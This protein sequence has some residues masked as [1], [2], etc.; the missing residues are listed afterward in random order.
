M[1]KVAVADVRRIVDDEEMSIG[2]GFFKIIRSRE[3]FTILGIPTEMYATNK[4][5]IV[6]SF[7]YVVYEGQAEEV[8]GFAEG[9]RAYRRVQRRNVKG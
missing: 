7:G 6:D 9:L 8:A 1:A 4:Y 3:M 2:D 5:C